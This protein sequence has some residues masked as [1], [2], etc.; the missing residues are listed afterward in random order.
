ML[1]TSPLLK[2]Q[3]QEMQIPTGK[4]GSQCV[5]LCHTLYGH[6]LKGLCACVTSVSCQTKLIKQVTGDILLLPLMTQS[7]F[8]YYIHYHF[9]PLCF[10]SCLS[11][12]ETVIVITD[13][14]SH[15]LSIRVPT[16]L[17]YSFLKR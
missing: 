17:A 6:E 15:C 10:S 4:H 11:T 2:W 9:V 8:Y 5:N 16:W 7:K 13:L 12:T 14:P 1:N 3:I